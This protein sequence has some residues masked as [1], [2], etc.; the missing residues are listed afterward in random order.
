V[1]VS[2]AFVIVKGIIAVLPFHKN[3]VM[4]RWLVSR[5]YQCR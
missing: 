5:N 2:P 3:D 4:L 1:T